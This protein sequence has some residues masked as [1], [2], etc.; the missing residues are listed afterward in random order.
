MRIAGDL[1]RQRP[2]ARDAAEKKAIDVRL[3]QLNNIAQVLSSPQ[4]RARYDAENAQ[5]TF[6][7]PSRSVTP[8]LDERELRM[9]WVHQAIRDF[10]HRKGV[11]VLPLDDLERSDFSADHTPNALLDELLKSGRSK[12]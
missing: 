3:T 4:L 2:N 6:F 10:L 11:S 5:L 8:V 1:Q 9:R 12:R 7:V